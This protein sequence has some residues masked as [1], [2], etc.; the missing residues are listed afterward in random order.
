MLNLVSQLLLVY[1]GITRALRPSDSPSDGSP[2]LSPPLSSIGTSRQIVSASSQFTPS[3]LHF[4]LSS[5]KVFYSRFE[6]EFSS[7]M[8]T[9]VHISAH[10]PLGALVYLSLKVGLV[11]GRSSLSDNTNQHTPSYSSNRSTLTVVWTTILACPRLASRRS[12]P[13][14]PTTLPKQMCAWRG[15]CWRRPHS[16]RYKNRA[17]SQGRIDCSHTPA[18]S[19]RVRYRWSFCGLE[20]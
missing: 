12:R 11:M 16:R 2:F 18:C 1:L 13:S 4:Y 20:E 5:S 14:Q 19:K 15:R 17:R 9:R 10:F 6:P 8:T 7:S 3:I